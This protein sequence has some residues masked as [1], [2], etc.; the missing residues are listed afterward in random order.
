[1]AGMRAAI[2]AGTFAAYAAVFG[3]QAGSAPADETAA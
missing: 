2:E 3:R 1:M